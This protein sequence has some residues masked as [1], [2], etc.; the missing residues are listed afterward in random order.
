[1]NQEPAAFPFRPWTIIDL[2]ELPSRTDEEVS[3]IIDEDDGYLT[4]KWGGGAYDLDI[5]QIHRP[6]DLLWVI[7]HLTRKTWKGMTPNRIGA[8]IAIVAD[9]RGWKPYEKVRPHNEAPAPKASVL[10]ERAKMTPDLRYRVITR[11]G[12]RCRCCGA[13][14][15]TGAVLHVDHIHP[16]SKG[17]QTIL[18]NLQTL[19]T[20]CNAGKGART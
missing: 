12:Y 7:D 2:S 4:L 19:C 18:S 5:R 11:D 13:S 15:E 1:M 17:G 3:G 8:L 20:V 9:K 16:V 10:A 6:E 14:V